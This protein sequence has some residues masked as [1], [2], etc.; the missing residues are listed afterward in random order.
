M[1]VISRKVGQQVRIGDQITVTIL[2]TQ[3]KTVR[4]GIDAPRE[5]HVLRTELPP[6]AHPSIGEASELPGHSGGERMDRNAALRPFADRRSGNDRRHR[7]AEAQARAPRSA[8]MHPQRWTVATMRE[9]VHGQ[10]APRAAIVSGVASCS[11]SE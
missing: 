11:A 3:G 6:L 10:T 8:A 9:R 5:V 2:K 7:G 4:V 1:L